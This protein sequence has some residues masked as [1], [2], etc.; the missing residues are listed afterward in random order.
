MQVLPALRLNYFQSTYFDK[1]TY[2]HIIPLLTSN[3]RATVPQNNSAVAALDRYHLPC[4]T[5]LGVA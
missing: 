3:A 2:F 5:V 1:L 4:L